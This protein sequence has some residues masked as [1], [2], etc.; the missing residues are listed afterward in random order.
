MIF[1]ISDFFIRRPVFATVCSVIITL[2]GAACIFIL[3]IA[4]YPEISPP[5]VSV[6]SAYIGANAETVE[7]TVTNVLEREL[8]GI[9][10]VKYTTSTSANDGS[11]NITLT[12]DLSKNKD[13]AAVDVQN[14][15]SSVLSQLPGPVQQ[16]GVRVSKQSSGF[17]LA[18][19]VY[20]EKD[21]KGQPLYDDLY[22]S[23]YSDLYI[24]DA[25]K[26]IKGVGNVTIFGERKYAMRLWID[27]SRLAARKLTDQDVVSAIQQQN[28]QV[29]AGQI[30]QQP[31]PA[32]QEYQLSVSAQGRLKDVSEFEDLVISTAADGTLTKFK[33]VG[34]VE[35]GAENYGSIL[36]FNKIRGIGL[37]ISQL[38]DANALDVQ[39]SVKKALVELK[40]TFPPGVDYEIA[41]D[42]TLFI[43]AGAEEVVL[44]LA[45]AVSLVILI[46]FLFLQNWR[47]TLIPAIAIPVALIGT[48]L[49]VKLLNFNINTLTLFGL[50]LATGL[51]VDDA[52]VIVEDVTRRIQEGMKPFDAAIQSMNELL[53]AVIASSLVLIAVFVPVAFFPGTT[54]QLYKQFALTIAFS[55]T[56][57]TFNAITLTPTLS[58]LLL[59]QE[60]TPNNW[61]FNAINWLIDNTRKNYAWVLG[62]VT[63]IKGIILVLFIAALGFTYWMY[64]VVP[65]GFLP[66]E[67]QGYFITI[68]QAPEGVSLNYT[69]KV[70]EQVEAIMTQPLTDKDGKV[71]IDKDGKPV[72]AYPEI[73]NIFAVGGFSF[74]G[75]T[76]N[77]GIIFATLK[78][79]KERS[80]SVKDIIGGFAPFPSGLLPSLLSIKEAIVVPF[81]PPAIIG[82]SNLGGFEFQLQ[83]RTNQGFGALESVL[84]GFIGQASTYPGTPDKPAPPIIAGLRPDFAGNTPQLSVEVDR[85]K[86]NAL[87]VSLEDIF[88]S[89]QTFLGSR[90]VNDFNQF[91]RTYRVYVQ[92]DKEYRSTPE[93]INKIYVRSRRGDMI[94]LSN[95]VT[96]KQV[97]A[98]SIINHYNLFR[99]VLISGNTAPGVS[100][101]QVIDAMETVA[102]QTLPAGF[103]YEWTGLSLEEISSGGQAILIFGLGLVFVFLVLAAQYENYVDP[104]IIMLTV[105]LAILGA[106][107]AVFISGVGNDIYTQIGFVMLI[108]MASKNAILIVEFANQLRDHGLSI[109]AAVVEASKQR[110]RPILMTAI[111]TI[112]GTYPLAIATGAGAAAR[113]S[114]G[115]AVIGG[116]CVATVLSLFIVPVLYITIKTM[117]DR[118]KKDLYQ[119]SVVGDVD[120]QLDGHL[121]H[122]EANGSNGSSHKSA[123]DSEESEIPNK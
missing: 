48:F 69:E 104:T 36:R 86:V 58:A 98:P 2:L 112:I 56:V 21:E 123:Q 39:R 65:T 70:L 31:A 54:G 110:L 66:E 114:L 107:I 92:A 64:Q 88:S 83:D 51:V 90:Y 19:G 96:V 3:P 43:E 102:K 27:P 34:R 74:S 95:L 91:G 8:N 120:G 38:P 32:G 50:T 105:P 18:I 106:L 35:L 30:G 89:L 101:G 97:I 14:R 15:V 17:L 77:N 118:L 68:V 80:R 7:S 33:D 5:Q 23:N 9:E 44:S 73:E 29:G 40:P 16:V 115:T 103:G 78:P 61:F 82:L 94:P 24:V 49:F 46:I 81:P 10:G 42:T 13:L 63:K 108:G 72:P 12:F 99:S 55:I 11:S 75:T 119:P 20:A 57:S 41:F 59:R 37:G 67:D 62:K 47:S 109:T 52:I 79:W 84:Y 93:D 121:N 60:E 6:R 122:S 117:Q 113:K 71:V 111:S 76:P 100:S 85:D 53:G 45:I 4:Q 22:L 116:M 87:Q 28:L 26:K 25:L 1:S